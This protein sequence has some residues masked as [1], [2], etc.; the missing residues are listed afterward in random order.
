MTPLRA[1]SGAD[2]L[3]YPEAAPWR[4]WHRRCDPDPDEERGDYY[5]FTLDRVVDACGLLHWTAHLMK[6]PWLAATNWD[7]LL[8][9]AADGHGPIRCTPMRRTP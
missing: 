1:Y 7:D 6:K 8:R 5:H 9:G 2:L 3:D 4:V